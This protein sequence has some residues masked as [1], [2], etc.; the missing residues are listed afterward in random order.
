MA[1][2][3]VL[4][5]DSNCYDELIKGFSAADEDIDVTRVESEGPFLLEL[6]EQ[7]YDAALLDLE[8]SKLG[9]LNAVRIT[10]RIRPKLPLLVLS[11]DASKTLGGQVLQEGVAYYEIKPVD[12]TAI[13]NALIRTLN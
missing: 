12:P 2:I 8:H 13:K 4:C 11:H 9:G 10:R 5:H 7:D 3:L 1:S 6:L